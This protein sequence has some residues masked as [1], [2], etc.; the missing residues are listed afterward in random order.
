M[1]VATQS[2]LTHRINRFRPARI[3]PIAL[4][5]A[6]FLAPAHRAGALIGVGAV[7][8][9][10]DARDVEIVGGIAYVADGP[11]GLRVIDV[12]NPAA[13]FEIGAFDTLGRAMDVEVVDGIAYV[14]NYH[15]LLVIDVS[16]PAAPFKIGFLFPTGE[17]WWDVEVIGGL[18]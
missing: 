15:D 8:T 11:S 17:A 1:C 9:P 3:L 18:A 16:D 7:D 2:L 14:A 10:G 5:I 12:S 6:F 13:P 4:A